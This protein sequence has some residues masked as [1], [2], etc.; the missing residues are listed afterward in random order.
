MSPA[1]L[2]EPYAGTVSGRQLLRVGIAL[3]VLGFV[4][5]L[6]PSQVHVDLEGG[7]EDAFFS[8]GTALFPGVS[9]A[10]EGSIPRVACEQANRGWRVGGSLTVLLGM[11]LLVVSLLRGRTKARAD[12]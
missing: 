8:C 7:V 5:L 9:P 12:A 10:G 1:A 6:V 11:A 4:A 3:V 2:P